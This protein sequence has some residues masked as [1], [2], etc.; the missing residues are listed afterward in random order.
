MI[1]S[2]TDNFYYFLSKSIRGMRASPL[3]YP[4]I[5]PLP[6]VPLGQGHSR[7]CAQAPFLT[8]V[9]PHTTASPGSQALEEDSFLV[10]TNL[11]P[12][13]PALNRKFTGASMEKFRTQNPIST[14]NTLGQEVAILLC[15]FLQCH[16]I[17]NMR[18]VH[19]Y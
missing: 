13:D 3:T 10:R 1:V 12:Q 7:T 6:M 11:D 4:R 17:K 14:P 15:N 18:L 8:A 19:K 9:S 5:A 2:K 16:S